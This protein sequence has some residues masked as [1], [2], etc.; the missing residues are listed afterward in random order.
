LQGSLA[1]L[2]GAR[3]PRL[4]QPSD[5]LRVAVVGLNGRG[6]EHV[7]ALRALPEV[8]VVA[9]CDVDEQ[10]LAREVKRLRERGAPRLGLYTDFRTLLERPDLD[11]LS[12]ATPNHWHA[13]QTIWACQAG[14]D[15]YVEKPATHVFA[16]AQALV[17]AA[18]KYGRIVQCGMQSRCSPAIRAALAWVRAGNLGTLE[19]ARGLCYKPRPSIGKTKGNQKLPEGVDYDLWCGPAPLL[20]LRRTRLHYDWHWSWATG[21][22]DLGNQGV[23]A[24]DVAR[25]ALGAEEWPESVTSLGAR[26]GYD[27]D[28]ET[29]NT[30][31]VYFAYQPAPLL[32][33]V[34]GLPR[35]QAAQSGDWLA[36][37]DD[38]LGVKVGVVLHCAG[39]TLRIPS[40]T[41]AVAYD[42]EGQEIRR[43]EEG[44]DPFA[45]WI[46][47][48]RSRRVE[49]LAAEIEVGA[50]SSA[51][52]QLG[53]AS[54]RLAHATGKAALLEAVKSSSHLTEA[55]G[56]ALAHLEANG[57]DPEK[58]PLALGPCLVLDRAQSCF[59]DPPAANE[60]LA[61]RFREP[62]VLPR[63]S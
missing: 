45:N 44:G 22:G 24:L 63:A 60:L 5:A 46:A 18:R 39:G 51:W 30:Q 9:L 8:Q 20:A 27:D 59:Q 53:N 56:R 48:V 26:L 14:K 21:D 61:G 11:A 52:V 19:L 16:E 4:A 1:V 10:V 2:A 6:A 34:R 31:L 15:V 62:F 12:I 38:F 49:E 40:Y 13:L 43:W 32:F 29:P 55:T 28:G 25:W 17:S 33:E 41:G 36:G 47:A 58:T 50:R 7:D 35:D 57:V 54:Q 23:H 37:M 3:V 42:A